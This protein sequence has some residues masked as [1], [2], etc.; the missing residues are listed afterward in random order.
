MPTTRETEEVLG[1]LLDALPVGV[2]VLRGDEFR[3]TLVNS[4]YRALD[5]RRHF[6]G[7][8]VAETW[9]ELVDTVTPLLRQVVETGKP[10]HAEDMRLDIHRDEAPDLREAY[11][12]FSYLALPLDLQGRSGVL[13]AVVETTATVQA[14]RTALGA[15]EVAEAALQMNRRLHDA[16]TENQALVGELREAL[17]RVRMLSGLLPICMYCKRIRSDEG[18]WERIE[19]YI[20]AHSEALFSHGMCPECFEDHDAG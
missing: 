11:F 7:S 6:V 18:S 9:P 19:A 14:R 12:T 1:P 20:S 15:K 16:H 3:F 10:F 17:A 13:V 8:T 5:P 4:M 2:A